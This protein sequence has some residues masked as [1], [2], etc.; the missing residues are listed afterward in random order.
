MLTKSQLLF[1]IDKFHIIFIEQY[2]TTTFVIDYTC[3]FGGQTILLP[4]FIYFYMYKQTKGSRKFSAVRK[5]SVTLKSLFNFS[6][7]YFSTVSIEF[8]QF[9]RDEMAINQFY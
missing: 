5:T 9:H 3:F 1:D 6:Y 8:G 7:F 4:D 2:D